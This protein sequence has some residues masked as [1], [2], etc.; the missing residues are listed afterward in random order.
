LK[1]KDRVKLLILL[2]VLLAT[3]MNRHNVLVYRVY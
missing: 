3:K 1:G 2:L